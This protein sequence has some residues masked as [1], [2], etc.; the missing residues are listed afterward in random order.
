MAEIKIGGRTYRCDPLPATECLALSGRFL[1]L[2]A[3]VLPLLGAA[4]AEG[5]KVDMGNLQDDFLSGLASAVLAYDFAA[6]IKLATELA[7][8]CMVDNEQVFVDGNLQDAG[9]LLEVAMWAASVQFGPFM[10]GGALGRAGAHLM[11]LMPQ[12]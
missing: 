11:R 9:E 10:R 12:A 3:P 6:A 1:R 2:I 4:T 5:G 7:S 8:T